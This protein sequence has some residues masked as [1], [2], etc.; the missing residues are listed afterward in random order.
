[1]H[2]CPGSGCLTNTLP[3]VQQ[4]QIRHVDSLHE[5]KDVFLKVKNWGKF[6]HSDIER[7]QIEEVRNWMTIPYFVRTFERKL[8]RKLRLHHDVSCFLD[9][10]VCCSILTV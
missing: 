9:L 6:E 2:L 4:E 1:M 7:N 3:E 8:V 5:Y 10:S